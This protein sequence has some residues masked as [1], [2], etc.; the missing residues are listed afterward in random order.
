[1]AYEINL[2][3]ENWIN[4]DPDRMMQVETWIFDASLCD[5][6]FWL[7][8]AERVCVNPETGKDMDDFDNVH[9][10]IIFTGI[11]S[12]FKINYTDSQGDIKP[13][14]P[15]PDIL[16]AFLLHEASQG[17]LCA[18]EEVPEVIDFYKETLD[19][20]KPNAHLKAIATKFV[21]MWLSK[22]RAKYLGATAKHMTLEQLLSASER[23]SDAV[24]SVSENTDSV[25]L[26]GKHKRYQ[27][28]SGG[29]L[30]T[31]LPM[32]SKSL[33]GLF[34]GDAYMFQAPTG[35]GKTVM[36]VQLL[37]DLVGSSNCGI[38]ISTEQPW[39]ELEPRIIANTCQIDIG[40]E[41]LK[42]RF[43]YE[44]LKSQ[45]F[46]I[47]KV[48]EWEKAAAGKFAFFHW[49]SDNTQSVKTDLEAT[50][51]KGKALLGKDPDFVILD[52]IG[53]AIGS[54]ANHENLRFTYQNTSDA[55]AAA[56]QKHKF[57][58]IAFA[59][60]KADKVYYTLS[61][62]HLAE[63]KTMHRKYTALVGITAITAKDEK[64]MDGSKAKYENKQYFDVAKSR[65][66]EP[67][68]ISVDRLFQFQ[69]FQERGRLGGGHDMSMQP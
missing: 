11:R 38:F 39:K 24:S 45:K 9:R 48:D 1:M 14:N 51:R 32:L 69:K 64:E 30:L 65:K 13:N 21:P 43:D 5:Y 66:G 67:A 41:S 59:Q 47:S 40:H 8:V 28:V 60:S 22:K 35:G 16:K 4:S 19:R 50:L 17:N 53:G 36:A 62:E 46:N 31:T 61:S 44:S 42:N 49:N 2:E 18:T 3:P 7:S 56:A 58:G 57:I 15:D 27:E 54:D 68:R 26:Y 34:K 37:V 29:I 33:G 10:N 20:L 23:H 55:F 12:L 63:C 52:W 25:I 6:D